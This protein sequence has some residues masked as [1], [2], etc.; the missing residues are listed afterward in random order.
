D[1]DDV[2]AAVEVAHEQL[3]AL[4][5]LALHVLLPGERRDAVAVLALARGHAHEPQLGDVAADRGLRDPYAALGEPLGDLR[6][7]GEELVLDELSDPA[8]P[9]LLAR[10]VYAVYQ[11]EASSGGARSPCTTRP[12]YGHTAPASGDESSFRRS[13]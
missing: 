8:L 1:G 3:E 13:L 7:G 2:L 4:P 9:V 12:R 5:Q 6:L 10:H 11:R